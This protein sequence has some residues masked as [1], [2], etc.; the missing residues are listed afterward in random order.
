MVNLKRLDISDNIQMY[1]TSDML[2]AQAQKKAEGSGQSFDYIENKKHRD[3]LL[4]NMPQLEHLVCDIVL[5]V[6]ILE[7]REIKNLLPNIKTINKIPIEV[8]DL[9]ERTKLKKIL[10]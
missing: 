10:E 7:N 1:L 5:E 8:K 6:Y 3:E 2:L 4:N 9:S